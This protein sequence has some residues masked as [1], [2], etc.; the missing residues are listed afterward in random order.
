M[1]RLVL[2]YTVGNEGPKL[3]EW[4]HIRPDQPPYPKVAEII[5]KLPGWENCRLMGFRCGWIRDKLDPTPVRE[6]VFGRLTSQKEV[7]V[8]TVHYYAGHPLEET[9]TRD[10]FRAYLK[11]LAGTIPPHMME[12]F[13][14]F[15]RD[16]ETNHAELNHVMNLLLAADLEGESIAV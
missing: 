10:E 1:L 3:C 6:V 7:E 5:R 14:R 16:P 9:T 13:T 2:F 8:I 15:S 12:C 11:T 4:S